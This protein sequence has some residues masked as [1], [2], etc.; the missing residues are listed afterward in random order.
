MVR[1]TLIASAAFGIV[2]SACLANTVRIDYRVFENENGVDLTDWEIYLEVTDNGNG[3]ALIAF[4]NASQNAAASYIVSGIAF[5]DSVWEDSNVGS[6]VITQEYNSVDFSPGHVPSPPGCLDDWGGNSYEFAAVDYPDT[7]IAGGDRIDFTVS[8]SSSFGDL[9]Y[10]MQNPGF[11]NY[12]HV[13][14]AGPDG[15][16]SFWAVTVP[17]PTTVF[18]AGLGLLGLG[19]RRRRGSL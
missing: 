11:R 15:Q 9:I 12:V 7:G 14:N 13:Q 8:Y 3:T 2:A 16:D 19:V 5:E 4:I 1:N 10:N 18:L 6:L 17:L